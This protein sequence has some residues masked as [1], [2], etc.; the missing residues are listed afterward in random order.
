MNTHQD[1]ETVVFRKKPQKYGTTEQDI[2]KARRQDANI[3]THKK[4]D[5]SNKNLQN[6][7]VN[8]RKLDAE[9][10]DFHHKKVPTEVAKAIE[11]GRIAKK[12]TQDAL[13][14]ALN[15]Q[16][17]EINEIEKGQA[18]YNGQVLAKIKKFLDIKT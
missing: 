2:N 9:T 7:S 4:T 1:W 14:R 11:R 18:L 5:V 13:A 8:T 6:Q 3:D 12:L 16:S 17:R 10:E 15:M